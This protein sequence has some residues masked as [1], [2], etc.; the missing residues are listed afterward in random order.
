MALW[1]RDA[2]RARQ[3]R[4][5]HA[6]LHR[7][8]TASAALPPEHGYRSGGSVMLQSDPVLLSGDR[9]LRSDSA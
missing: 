5:S 6:H 9:H 7:V 2:R 4:T 8:T 1:V 3:A